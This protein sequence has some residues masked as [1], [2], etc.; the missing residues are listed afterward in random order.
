MLV[1]SA[2]WTCVN[3]YNVTSDKL[4]QFVNCLVTMASVSELKHGIRVINWFANSKRNPD[5][6]T[7]QCGQT[8]LELRSNFG[9]NQA[10]LT[11]QEIQGEIFWTNLH[12]AFK[13]LKIII[14]NCCYFSM[15]NSHGNS[16][17]VNGRF[18]S[19]Q[20]ATAESLRYV[21][22]PNE[23]NDQNFSGIL[24]GSFMALRARE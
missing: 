11:L 10:G 19:W 3:L 6:Y 18:W 7:F 8:S 14:N 22:Q 2:R 4:W 12:I 9:N 1:F 15:F 17:I 24:G 5:V 16:G 13:C 21:Q 20:P 23:G